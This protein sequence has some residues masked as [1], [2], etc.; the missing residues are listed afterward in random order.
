MTESIAIL[1]ELL[2]HRAICEPVVLQEESLEIWL[3]HQRHVLANSSGDDFAY[4]LIGVDSFARCC[5]HN[6]HC[7][8]K[9]R[10]FPMHLSGTSKL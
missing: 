8:C 3:G 10:R 5:V 9:A 7:F 4:V 6:V 2:L 1:S